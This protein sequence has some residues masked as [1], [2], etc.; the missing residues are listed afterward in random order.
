VILPGICNGAGK[1]FYFGQYQGFF[2]GAGFG[3]ISRTAET[4]RPTQF[5][6]KLIY[7]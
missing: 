2:E 6:L 4:S 5:S 1:T 3:E 7:E